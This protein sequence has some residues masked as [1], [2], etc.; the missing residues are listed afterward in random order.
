VVRAAQALA[1]EPFDLVLDC[2]GSF[3][4][5]Q[6]AWAG[7]SAPDPRAG[8]LATELAAALRDA[9]FELER[10]P[11][12]AHVTLV[13]H[14]NRPCAEAPSEPINWMASAFALVE[15]DLRTGRYVEKGRW[16]GRKAR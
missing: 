1:F 9:G 12:A 16:E 3:A 4:R 6:V 15:S 2:V 14:I 5:A 8:R 7:P 11:F 13:R 10:R